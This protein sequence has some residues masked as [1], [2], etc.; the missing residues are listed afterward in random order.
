MRDKGTVEL[1]GNV[2]AIGE[3]EGRSFL[4]DLTGAGE[5]SKGGLCP[6]SQDSMPLEPTPCNREGN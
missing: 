1:S 5:S 4:I 6:G 2:F 3:H